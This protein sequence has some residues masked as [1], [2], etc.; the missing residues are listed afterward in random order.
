M[1]TTLLSIPK[2]LQ[3]EEQ[4]VSEWQR[5]F[6]EAT[7]Q[8]K[9]EAERS[10]AVFDQAEKKLSDGWAIQLQEKEVCIF[11]G[12]WSKVAHLCRYPTN[13]L[14]EYAS[15]GVFGIAVCMCNEPC[16]LVQDCADIGWPPESGCPETYC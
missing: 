13:T 10:Q 6:D 7:R 15:L 14:N 2:K 5:R 1:T 16:P 9:E 11:V 4:V 3:R 8:A 12:L